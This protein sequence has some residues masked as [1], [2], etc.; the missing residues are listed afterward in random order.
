M[1]GVVGY[2]EFYYIPLQI[3]V[4]LITSAIKLTIYATHVAPT[5]ISVLGWATN[6]S[7][8]AKM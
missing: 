7:A 3:E 8:K 5:S 6:V 1:F 2:Y 4:R